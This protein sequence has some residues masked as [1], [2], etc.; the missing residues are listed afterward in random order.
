MAT[1]SIPSIIW[2]KLLVS[3][4]ATGAKGIAKG[5]STE[6]SIYV[7][8]QTMGNLGGQTN[9]GIIDTS[10]YSK[11]AFISKFYPDGSVAWTRLIGTSSED[12]ALAVGTA[13][14]G[15]V[16]VAGVTFGALD[17][18][19]ASGSADA[20]VTK[21]DSNGTKAWTRLLGTSGDEYAQGVATGS[22]GSIY[23]AG[24]SWGS[25]DGESNGGNADAF[26]TKFNANGTKAWTRLLGTS[27][28]NSANAITTSADGS[29]YIAGSTQGNLEGQTNAGSADAFVAKFS[30]DGTK[31]WTRLIG[32]T[33][34]DVALS[35]SS[36]TD[37]SVYIAGMTQGAFDS[38][39]Y[40]GGDYDAFVTKIDSN[41]VK[42]WTKLFGTSGIDVANSI[43]TGDDSSVYIGGYTNGNLDGVGNSGGGADAFLTK[44]G[45]DG[46]KI[47]TKLVG[48]PSSDEAS[49]VAFVSGGLATGGGI[50]YVAG[51]TSGNL[52]GE[53]NPAGS[54]GFVAQYG[55]DF[56]PPNIAITSDKSSLQYGEI[57]TLTFTLSESSTDFAVGD[58]SISGGSISGFTRSSGTS[59]TATFTPNANST[60]NGVISVASGKFSDAAGN[61]NADGADTNNTVTI[62]VN[63][64][65]PSNPICFAR[66]T[67]I[68]TANQAIQVEA[69]ATGSTLQSQLGGFAKC[70]WIGY[71]RRTPEF[72]QFQDYLPVKISAG[73]LDNHVPL[74]DLYLSPDH[75]VLVDGHL[76]HAKALVNGKTIVQMTEWAGDIEY[77][78]IETEAHEIIYAEGVPCETFIDNVSREQFDN[79]A[80]YQALYPNTRMMKELPLPRVKFKRQLPTMIK[81]RLES[82]ITELD[83]Q[84]KV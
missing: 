81:Q 76:I 32:S 72:A 40:S 73:A 51:L 52:G 7:V 55:D 59:Y 31:V 70:R 49:A 61:M 8:G 25:L 36:A 33:S 2:T 22:D 12:G 14:D 60:T 17:G 74:R 54:A 18:Q 21:F 56:T 50:V 69:L 79:Y 27:G 48:T 68:H 38:N 35:I 1:S 16:Y 20:F 67:L 53:Q 41:G 58:L 63:T 75:A 45:A 66:G 28:N 57:A 39:S 64:I 30:S 6:G 37:G 42:V 26:L 82:R 10:S 9:N 29:I 77:Y 3:T 80:E 11:D 23:V 5:P 34:S 78:H 71:Q 15:S 13:F 84:H 43:I 4:S 47:W 19:V 62:T 46:S 44:Y 24:Y 83:R 65:Q